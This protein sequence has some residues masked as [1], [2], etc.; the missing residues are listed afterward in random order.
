MHR[1][2]NAL[3]AVFGVA[4]ASLH[5]PENSLGARSA[6]EFLEFLTSIYRDEPD[7]EVFL[8]ADAS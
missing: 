1:S 2:V 5:A 6:R 8:S 3:V 7:E 4:F